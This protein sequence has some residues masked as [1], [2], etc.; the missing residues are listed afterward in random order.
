[1][2]QNGTCHYDSHCRYKDLDDCEWEKCEDKRQHKD[3]EILYLYEYLK[4]LP[5]CFY[6]YNEKPACSCQTCKNYCYKKPCRSCNPC[7]SYFD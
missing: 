1:M 5:K 2:L 7:K 6:C 4:T 3:W